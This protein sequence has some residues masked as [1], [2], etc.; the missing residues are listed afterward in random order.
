MDRQMASGYNWRELVEANVSRFER[1]IG[2]TL[3]SRTARRR[4]AEMA[5]AVGALNRTLD[6]GRPGHVRTA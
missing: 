5:I 2:H 1:G 3:R 4:V 6:L